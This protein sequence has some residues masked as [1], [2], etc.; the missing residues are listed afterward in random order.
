M[1]VLP[2]TLFQKNRL[3]FIKLF[4]PEIKE[5]EAISFFQG[6]SEVPLYSSDVA[7]PEYQEAFFYYLFGVTEMDCFAVIDFTNERSVLFVPR[8]DNFYKI[9]MTTLS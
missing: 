8:L 2:Q 1:N 7:Y 6:A 5:K 9:W 3:Q 4:K